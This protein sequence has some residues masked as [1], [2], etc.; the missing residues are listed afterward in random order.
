[1]NAHFTVSAKLIPET[2]YSITISVDGKT[3]AIVKIWSQK[4]IERF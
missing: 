3:L 4:K 2:N 1:M